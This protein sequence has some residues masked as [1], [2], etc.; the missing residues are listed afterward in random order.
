[1]ALEPGK[2]Q[3]YMMDFAQKA[4]VFVQIGQRLYWE[5]TGLIVKIRKARQ[6]TG[7]LSCVY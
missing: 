7:R 5:G 4:P 1:M 2:I 6:R 3:P